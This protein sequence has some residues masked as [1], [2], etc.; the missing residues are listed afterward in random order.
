MKAHILLPLF[1][2]FQFTALLLQDRNSSPLIVGILERYPEILLFNLSITDMA[3]VLFSRV[4][5]L[6]Q[7]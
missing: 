1:F 4:E 3:A 6:F 7:L 5:L 2:H